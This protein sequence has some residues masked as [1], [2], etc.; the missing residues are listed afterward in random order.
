MPGVWALSLGKLLAIHLAGAG[1][2]K[3]GT[4]A[5]VASLI[6]TLA[7]DLLLIPL[8]GIQ[9]AAIAS[10]VAYTL[11]TVIIVPRLHRGDR[12]IVQRSSSH[13]HGRLAHAAH[14]RA[15]PARQSERE[16]MNAMNDW[17][18]R[19]IHKVRVAPT[20]LQRRLQPVLEDYA[21]RMSFWATPQ[22]IE[23]WAAQTKLFFVLG[24]G[25]SGTVFIAR[26]LDQ[27]QSAYVCHE[28]VRRTFRAGVAARQDPQSAEM[29]VKRFRSREIFLRARRRDV[30]IYGEVNSAL[31]RH[32]YALTTVFPD[33]AYL[34]LVRDGRA[35]V[36]SMTARATLT[37]AD[38]YTATL[39]PPPGDP[40]HTEWAQMDR[41]ARLCWY[42]QAENAFVRQAIGVTVRFEDL[43]HDYAY[44]KRSCWRRAAFISHMSSGPQP[45]PTR[46][47]RLDAMP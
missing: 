12:P 37:T 18:R 44:F 9:G 11:S 26:L 46:K 1:R 34:H 6:A 13:A 5:A 23:Q 10:S 33:A 38:P 42:W 16:Q 43:L 36:R 31:R 41:F 47:T 30:P 24:M 21:V 7:L 27:D 25:R 2:P 32:A 3:V 22:R 45:L 14:A 40:W 17:S 35:V 19:W 8:W 15:R 39:Q 4:V 29:Y 28:P 20:A